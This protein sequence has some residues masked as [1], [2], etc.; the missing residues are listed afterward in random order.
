MEQLKKLAQEKG[1]ATSDIIRRACEE[2]LAKQEK[3]RAS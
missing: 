3:P 2:Y 1:L